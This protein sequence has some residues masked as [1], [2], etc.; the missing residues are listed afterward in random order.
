MIPGKVDSGGRGYVV[1]TK[2]MRDERLF[3]HGA[4]GRKVLLCVLRGGE[5]LNQVIV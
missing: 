4:P 3:M 5:K 1:R 2:K